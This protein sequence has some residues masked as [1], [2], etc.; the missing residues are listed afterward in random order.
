[1]ERE[2]Q[3]P[4]KA[5]I[6]PQEEEIFIQIPGFKGRKAQARGLRLYQDSPNQISQMT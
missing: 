6:F 4:A 1:L 2:V 5:R 3:V